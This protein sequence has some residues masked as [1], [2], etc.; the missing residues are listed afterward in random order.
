MSVTEIN[1]VHHEYIDLFERV[2]AAWT[3]HQFS[4]GIGHVFVEES[5]R[6]VSEVDFK[7]LFEELKLAS[8]Q[9]NSVTVG[10]VRSRLVKVG[11]DLS[12][13]VSILE[14]E[15]SKLS[16]SFLRLF[17]QRVKSYDQQVLIRMIRFYLMLQAGRKWS[18]GRIDKVDYLSTCLAESICGSRIANHRAKVLP[19]LEKF[20]DQA[21][22]DPLPPGAVDSFLGRLEELD[23]EIATMTSLA[24]LREVSLIPRFRDFK[25]SLGRA[26]FMPDIHERVLQTNL[27]LRALVQQFYSHEERRL[28]ADYEEL[29]DLERAVAL[30][31]D[32]GREISQVHDDVERFE[33]DVQENNVR[34]DDLADVRR[35]LSAILPKVQRLGRASEKSG[36]PEDTMPVRL[37][38][39]LAEMP[40]WLGPERNREF[41]AL[42]RALD[43][44]SA[45]ITPEDAVHRPEIAPYELET[46]EVIAYR[47][48]QDGDDDAPVEVLVLSAAAVRRSMQRDAD[49]IRNLPAEELIEE[50]SEGIVRVRQALR[51]AQEAMDELDTVAESARLRDEPEE[52]AELARLKIRLMQAYADIWL[53]TYPLSF[54]GD[55]DN[56]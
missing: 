43:S 18:P 41:V 54:L 20:W 21:S 14:E 52:G 1:E 22:K 55:E 3:Y 8:E 33:R 42:L 16:P 27:N 11:G 56:A 53:L 30:D 15:D 36:T 29:A 35:R 45:T 7:P 49:D 44:L 2:K 32:L 6:D 19:L 10:Q 13:I 4:R 31:P 26:F 12:R 37:A 38:E 46:R 9:L 48:L 23:S 5:I 34:L 40:P 51:I 47:R 39:A 25:H 50:G 24:Q 17:F 28:F